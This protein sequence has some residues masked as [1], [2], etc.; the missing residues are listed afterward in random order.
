MTALI[1]TI[2]AAIIGMF[3]SL[4]NP[5]VD[6]TTTEISRAQEQEIYSSCCFYTPQ[7]CYNNFER[8]WVWLNLTSTS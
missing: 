6:Q 4:G 7:N 8:T 1:K 5:E 2:I 3:G